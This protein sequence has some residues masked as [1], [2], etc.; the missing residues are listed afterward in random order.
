MTIDALH[1]PVEHQRD[2]HVASIAIGQ[3]DAN[4][5][6]CPTC[7][8][9]VAVG[10][11]RCVG[12]GTR[13]VDGVQLSKASRFIGLGL[14]AGILLGGGVVGAAMVLGQPAITSSVGLGTGPTSSAGPLGSAPPGAVP[15]DVPPAALSAL[16]QSTA[17]N[18]RLLA[19]AAE[20][21]RVLKRKSPAAEDIAP[22]LRSLASTAAFGD[23]LGPTVRTWDAGAAVGKGLASFYA[24]VARVADEGLQASLTNDRAYVNAGRRM[25]SV[26][27]KITDL[28]A[29]SRGL[30]KGVGVELPPLVPAK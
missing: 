18:Q 4:I 16:R 25:R 13:L 22:I 6:L 29:A 12:C 24:T 23:R 30:A 10:V 19:D 7:S 17:V 21:E 1:G 2:D 11:S 3:P 14:V 5:F 9:P 15:A 8:R 28:D 20:L 27:D 26:L